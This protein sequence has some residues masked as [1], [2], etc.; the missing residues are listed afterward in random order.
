[1]VWNAGAAATTTGMNTVAVCVVV[2]VPNVRTRNAGTLPT[3]TNAVLAATMTPIGATS[4]APVVSA[5]PATAGTARAA[6]NATLPQKM[7]CAVAVG[8]A[9]T[10]WADCAMDAAS[11]R[12]AGSWS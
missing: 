5:T 2:A 11:A 6:T 7:N 1:M 9:E 4:A 3:A 12:V 8:S 10:A